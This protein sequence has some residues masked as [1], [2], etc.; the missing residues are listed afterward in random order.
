MFKK[1]AV[2]LAVAALISSTGAAAAQNATERQA[3]DVVTRQL[4]AF[5]SG[6]FARAYSYA[7]PDI[8]RIFPTLESFM[9]MVRNGYL[10]VL[11]PGNYAFGRVEPLADGRL[12]WEVLIRGPDGADYTAAYYMERQSDGSWKVDGVSLREGAA[13][14]T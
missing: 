12:V 11:R 13:G 10:P 6:D 7:S 9:S 8:K 4:E 1:T 14:M 2:S 3:Q 5:L